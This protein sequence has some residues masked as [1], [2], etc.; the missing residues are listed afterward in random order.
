MNI[1]IPP[2]AN[3]DDYRIRNITLKLVSPSECKLHWYTFS[4]V[5]NKLKIVHIFMMMTWVDDVEYVLGAPQCNGRFQPINYGVFLAFDYDNFHPISKIC[6]VLR[7]GC[8]K[9]K[10][11]AYTHTHTSV[12]YS[13][14]QC[15][16]VPVDGAHKWRLSYLKCVNC[17]CR[18]NNEYP[19]FME[20]GWVKVHNGRGSSTMCKWFSRSYLRMLARYFVPE[21]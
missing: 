10:F 12:L 20:H 3:Q 15:P 17:K 18:I 16:P 14:V 2:P 8:F 7:Q 21:K 5:L 6:M 4:K 11:S 1:N 13:L 9:M 19:K